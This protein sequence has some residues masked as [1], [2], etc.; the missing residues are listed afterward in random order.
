MGGSCPSVCGD[1]SLLLEF[2][3]HTFDTIAILMAAIVGV[4]RHLAVRSRQAH[5]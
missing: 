5:R 1:A 3:E 4:D 2:V